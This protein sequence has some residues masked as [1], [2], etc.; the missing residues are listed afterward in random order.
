[1]SMIEEEVKAQVVITEVLEEKKKFE[2]MDGKDG[3]AGEVEK[4][5]GVRKKVVKPSVGAA[6]SNKLKMAQLVTAKR[7]VAKQAFVMVITLSRGRI[8]CMLC[9]VYCREYEQKHYYGMPTNGDK[10][11]PFNLFYGMSLGQLMGGKFGRYH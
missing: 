5:Q 8:R 4:R 6:A 7:V 3:V 2:D 9:A 11:L 1:M 10:E